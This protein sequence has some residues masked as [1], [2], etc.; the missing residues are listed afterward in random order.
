MSENDL[1]D[2]MVFPLHWEYRLSHG[3]V[4]RLL[5]APAPVSIGQRKAQVT[6]YIPFSPRWVNFGVFLCHCVLPEQFQALPGAILRPGFL[7][8]V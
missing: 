4:S 8:S 3:T 1:G 2:L 5:S 6:I 7:C